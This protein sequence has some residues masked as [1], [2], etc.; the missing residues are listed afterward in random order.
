MFTYFV[1]QVNQNGCESQRASLTIAVNLLP[2]SSFTS[3]TPEGLV[4]QVGGGVSYELVKRIERIN[5]YE[6][7]QAEAN[8]TGYFLITQTGPYSITV[9][10][11]NG[12]RA[13]VTVLK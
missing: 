6:I 4:V 13:T 5:E 12:C 10:G 8:Q 2:T 7:R 11:V 1:S 3:N 9:L